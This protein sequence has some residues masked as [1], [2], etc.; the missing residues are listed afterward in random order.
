MLQFDF[1][2]TVNELLVLPAHGADLL[3]RDIGNRGAD[4]GRKSLVLR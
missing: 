1:T 2:G 4:T 3:Q